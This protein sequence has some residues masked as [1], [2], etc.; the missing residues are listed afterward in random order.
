[1]K[2]SSRMIVTG[3]TIAATVFLAISCFVIANTLIKSQP[4]TV[5][6]EDGSQT[7]INTPTLYGETKVLTLIVASS[8]A[9]ISGTYLYFQTFKRT[10][11][12][13]EEYRTSRKHVGLTPKLE[14]LNTVKTVLRV[15][16]GPR[17]K[18]VEILVNSD[19]EILQKD[20][21]L[22]TGFPKANISRTLQQLEIMNII[23]RKR[24]GNTKKITLSDWMK[25]DTPVSEE[26]I[27]K[28]HVV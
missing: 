28:Q 20:L 7:V 1:M 11:A 17:R 27:E 10:S 12:E 15:L 16:R 26:K 19:G 3:R 4:I 14:E 24:Y 5:I 21:Y 23:Q 2:M 6:L 25:T 13:F 22:E 8:V 9:G 18:I